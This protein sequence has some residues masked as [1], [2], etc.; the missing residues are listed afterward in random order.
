MKTSR[1]AAR[2][3]LH[4]LVRI[5]PGPTGPRAA[6][7][8]SGLDVWEVIGVI[9]DNEGDA[10][11]AAHHLELPLELLQAAV[12]YYEAFPEE[13][14]ERIEGNRAATRDA[15]AAFLSEK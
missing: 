15:Y 9:C 4:P 2:V 7:V 11:E 13:I 8:G 12:T 1:L 6:L 3:A 5:A 14:G 10:A